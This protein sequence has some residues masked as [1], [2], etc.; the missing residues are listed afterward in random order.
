[1]TRKR[2]I[3]YLFVYYLVFIMGFSIIKNLA[4]WNAHTF[5]Q[6]SGSESN[7]VGSA[8]AFLSEIILS[9]IAGVILFAIVRTRPFGRLIIWATATV[10]PVSFAGLIIA[11]F[12]FGYVNDKWAADASQQLHTEIIK[13]L[14][15]NTFKKMSGYRNDFTGYVT[16]SNDSLGLI[17]ADTGKMAKVY[18]YIDSANIGPINFDSCTVCHPYLQKILST[19]VIPMQSF[20]SEEV[21]HNTDFINNNQCY[22]ADHNIYIGYC[23]KPGRQFIIIN[24]VYDVVRHLNCYE[25]GFQMDVKTPEAHRLE[26]FE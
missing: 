2:K 23:R 13:R 20:S 6:L 5:E 17:V 25:I 4:G 9:L 16:A 7:F 11:H 26:L 15:H 18:I 3:P 22:V 24:N 1:M 19:I 10:I 12:A 14:P 8:L 21:E